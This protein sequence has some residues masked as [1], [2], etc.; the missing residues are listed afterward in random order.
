MGLAPWQVTWLL[1]GVMMK[2]LSVFHSGLLE[3]VPC[4]KLKAPAPSVVPAAKLYPMA[5]RH[6]RTRLVWR[7][8]RAGHPDSHQ[9]KNARLHP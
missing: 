1:L 2:F 7:Q 6:A 8:G 3:R 5:G 9:Q 4:W